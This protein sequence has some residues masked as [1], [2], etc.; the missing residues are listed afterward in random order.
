MQIFI[1]GMRQQFLPTYVSYT[2]CEREGNIGRA[3]SSLIRLC[4]AYLH[5]DLAYT[6]SVSE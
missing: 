1:T 5:Y 4:H 6:V 2:V 3:F